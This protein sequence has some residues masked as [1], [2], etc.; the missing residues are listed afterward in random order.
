MGALQNS[1]SNS[2][3]KKIPKK[4]IIIIQKQKQNGKSQDYE[5]TI[6][7]T[8]QGRK[9]TKVKERKRKQSKKNHGSTSYNRKYSTSTTRFSTIFQEE[10][11]MHVLM[12]IP[13]LSV[14]KLNI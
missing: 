7:K 6:V 13:W 4:N 11:K 9:T 8:C 12:S 3:T 10:F 5:I 1:G 2:K 14:N